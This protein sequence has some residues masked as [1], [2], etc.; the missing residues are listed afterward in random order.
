MISYNT[1]ID[2]TTKKYKIQLKQMIM[3]L[4]S[5]QKKSVVML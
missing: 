2:N 5:G 4:L 1:Q 3:I